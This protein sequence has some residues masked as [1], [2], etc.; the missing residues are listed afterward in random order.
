[1]MPDRNSDR[2]LVVMPNGPE[3]LTAKCLPK[4]YLGH[5]EWGKGK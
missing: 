5:R 1:M 2:S 4:F 3:W